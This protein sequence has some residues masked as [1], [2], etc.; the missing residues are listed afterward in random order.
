MESEDFGTHP[1]N[2]NHQKAGKKL[3]QRFRVETLGCRRAERSVSW[4]K[5]PRRVTADEYNLRSMR[6][7]P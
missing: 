7:S 1:E 5:R 2:E 4:R 3:F 6:A